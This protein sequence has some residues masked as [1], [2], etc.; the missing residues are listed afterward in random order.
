MDSVSGK[1]R[2]LE[3]VLGKIDALQREVERECERACMCLNGA[4]TPQPSKKTRRA[5]NGSSAAPG[6]HLPNTS[7][8]STSDLR[9]VKVLVN[10]HINLFM[11][12][13]S[14]YVKSPAWF[15]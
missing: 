14:L 10:Q 12:V 13:D 2:I 11:L 3:A 4:E 15:D 8:H 5:L 9:G 6:R 1:R 7:S